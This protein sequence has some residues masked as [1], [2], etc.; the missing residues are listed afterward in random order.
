MVVPLDTAE[1]GSTH[2]LSSNTLVDR[3]FSIVLED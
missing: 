3:A 2:E 1:E